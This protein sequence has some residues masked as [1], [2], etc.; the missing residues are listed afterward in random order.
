MHEAGWGVF[1]H[2]LAEVVASGAATSADDWNRLVD[3]FDVNAL[4]DQL[5]A[6]G[7]R[8]YFITLGQNSGC[9]CAPNAAYDRYVGIRSSKC[10]RRDLISDLYDVLHPRGIRLCVYLPSGAPDKDAAAMEALKW[11]PGRYPDYARPASGI[12]DEGRP[13]GTGDPRFAEFQFM[14]AEVV[15]E[16]SVRWGERVCGWW[17]DGCYYATA[18]YLHPDAPNFGTL[19]DAARAGNSD[20]IVAFNPGVQNWLPAISEHQDFTA[21]EIST[22]FPMPVPRRFVNQAQYQ[23]LSY[24]GENWGRSPTRFDDDW[25]VRYTRSVIDAGWAITWDVPILPTGLIDGGF[26]P[27][28]TTLGAALSHR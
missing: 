7:A 8:Y 4:A 5:A 12:D 26:M 15:R 25:V 20:S 18:M 9:Y 1:T 2:Y 28:L 24:L 23:I 16:W 17:F 19:A 22:T 10:S 6:T 13:W 27:Q 14:W 11:R 3:S 21:G